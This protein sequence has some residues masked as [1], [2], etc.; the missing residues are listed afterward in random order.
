MGDDEEA[1]TARIVKLATAYGRY[2]YRR[3][4]AML[5]E[6]GWAVNHKRVERMWRREGL[7]VP[8]KQPKRGRLRLHL[9][10]PPIDTIG[11]SS[12]WPFQPFPQPAASRRVSSSNRSF[13]ALIGGSPTSPR[14]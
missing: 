8:A 6:E 3:I 10:L 11:R 1:L 4:T 5:R 12:A 14:K 13:S 2:G 7:K 9:P